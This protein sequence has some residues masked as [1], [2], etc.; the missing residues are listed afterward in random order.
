MMSAEAKKWY[1]VQAPSG[2][3]SK[4]C[5][6][7]KEKIAKSEHKDYFGK[8]LVPTEEVV[9]R[10]N[11]KEYK[12]NRNL[13][14]G[15]ILVEM[16]MNV[17]TWHLVKAVPKVLCFLGGDRQGQPAPLPKQE[18]SQI[19]D[20][21]YTQ[22][23]PRPKTIFNV[24]ETVKITDGPFNDFNGIVE[25]VNY[26]KNRIRVSVSIFSRETPVEMEFTQ[27]KKI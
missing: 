4:V 19:M 25:M 2:F 5:L 13:F 11:G 12:S 10:R 16:E 17:E 7:L 6:A 3:E 8:I 18:V 15:Y 22:E 26:E 24:G 23:G 9:E 14:T 1:V 20:R 27:V 21:V